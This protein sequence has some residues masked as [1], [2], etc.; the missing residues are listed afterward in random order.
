MSSLPRVALAGATG[1]LGLPVL[2]ALLS[3]GCRVTVLSRVGG[4]RSK[5]TPH[6]YLI[7]KEVDFASVPDLSTALENAEVVV[8]SY[9]ITYRV[10]LK[11]MELAR[12]RGV[13]V[14]SLRLIVCWPFPEK[15]IKE[16]AGKVAAIVVPELN[17]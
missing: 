10:A 16:L 9:G 2:S 3:A 7:V 8:L 14:G 5:L 15:R 1:N 12:Q 13:K 4:N 6:P 11:G 17:L